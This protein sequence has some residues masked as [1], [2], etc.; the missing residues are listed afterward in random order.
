MI[1]ISLFRSVC[2]TTI[3]RPAR[4]QSDGRMPLLSEG[5]KRIRNGERK[6]IGEKS[7]CLIKIN[8]VLAEIF[9]SLSW[10]PYKVEFMLHS[11]LTCR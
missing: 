7:H 6:R 11:I 8:T 3:S 9:S 10:V 1:R 4:E 2:A 5:M